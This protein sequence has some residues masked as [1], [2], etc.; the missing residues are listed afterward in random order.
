MPRSRERTSRMRSR[1][2]CRRAPSGQ[3]SASLAAGARQLCPPRGCLRLRR[4]SSRNTTWRRSSVL[5]GSLTRSSRR[6]ESMRS[7]LA[8]SST[9]TWVRRSPWR[10]AR[11]TEA[12]SSPSF[13]SSLPVDKAAHEPRAWREHR[14]PLRRSAPTAARPSGRI[15]RCF[16]PPSTAP[17]ADRSAR[18]PSGRRDLRF[19]AFSWDKTSGARPHHDVTGGHHSRALAAKLSALTNPYAMHLRTPSLLFW[20]Q[21][22]RS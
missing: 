5:V 4:A 14:Q 9:E 6:F 20:P 12:A 2:R 11:A 15:R 7:T 21:G 13:L 19:P 3:S 8:S 1:A 10:A 18:A 22:A 16:P 17:G